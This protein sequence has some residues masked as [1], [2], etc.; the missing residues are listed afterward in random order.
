MAA[1]FGGTQSLHTNSK[2]EA[3][4]LPTEAS[5]TLA[6]RTQQVLAYETGIGDT[7]DPWAGSYAVE[8]LTDEIETRAFDYIKKIDALGGAVQAIEEG[9]QQKEIQE[10]AFQY[11][12]AIEEK[13][14]ILVGVN[15]FEMREKPV[16]EILKVDPALE[17]KQT[18]KLKALRQRRDASAVQ[19]AQANLKRAA[20]GSDNIMPH[21]LHAVKC[22][23]TLGEISD[24]LREVF[25]KY[26]EKIVL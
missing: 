4:A 11:Q 22:Y 25:G 15:K 10:A 5:A 19:Q 6:L 20:Q 26:Q 23:T 14:L 17:I 13:K 8:A 21:I 16:E 2:D 7:V 3:L 24:T 12:K 9:F 18:Q 1:V